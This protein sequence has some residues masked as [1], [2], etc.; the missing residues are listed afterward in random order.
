MLA[1][2]L[3]ELELSSELIIGVPRS[4]STSISGYSSIS[5]G[6]Y[7][8]AGVVWGEMGSATVSLSTLSACAFSRS[9]F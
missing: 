7:V 6:G 2:G 1:A 4:V 5:S 8:V 9:T 3:D